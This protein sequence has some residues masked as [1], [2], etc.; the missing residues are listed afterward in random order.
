[1]LQQGTLALVKAMSLLGLVCVI[2]VIQLQSWDFGAIATK[3][4]W[5]KHSEKV[6]SI[7][8]AR[9]HSP[10]WKCEKSLF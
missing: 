6:M 9:K 8:N 10:V 7:Y 1:M 2:L 3:V 4:V 5:G